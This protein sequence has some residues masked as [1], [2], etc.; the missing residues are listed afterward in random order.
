MNTRERSAPLPRGITRR[1]SSL[2]RL[3]HLGL[4]VTI[5]YAVLILGITFRDRNPLDPLL[6]PLAVTIV[7]TQSTRAPAAVHVYAQVNSRGG[8]HHPE[9]A[10]HAARLPSGQVSQQGRRHAQDARTSRARVRASESNPLQG[11]S[12]SPGVSQAIA[13]R[14]ARSRTTP[15]T[16]RVHLSG[17]RTLEI[18][19]LMV[20]SNSPLPPVNESHDALV[21][22]DALR[23]KP[24]P[25]VSARALPLARYLDT[26]RKRIERVGNRLLRLQGIGP[27]LRGHL[28]LAVTLRADGSVAA[29]H[30]VR[31]AHNPNLNRLALETIRAAQPFPPLPPIR[32]ARPSFRFIYEWRFYGH[33]EVTSLATGESPHS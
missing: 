31:P 6:H 26:W 4:L 5:A 3:F 25:A 23:P 9:R 27:G 21:G 8:S 17:L 14:S 22:S 11:S 1:P 28:L 7:D 15:L 33:H 30:F 12:S 32:N 19:H 16:Q 24:W 13:S 20:A 18:E 10:I 29:L 2:E